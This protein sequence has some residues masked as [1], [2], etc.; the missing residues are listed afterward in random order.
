MIVV[1]ASPAMPG[2]ALIEVTAESRDIPPQ[3]GDAVTPPRCRRRVSSPAAG[4]RAAP[5]QHELG[6][7]RLCPGA[8]YHA[9]LLVDDLLITYSGRYVEQLGGVA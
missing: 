6:L 9:G 2:E 4:R 3:G 5:T 8:R 7:H 1:P